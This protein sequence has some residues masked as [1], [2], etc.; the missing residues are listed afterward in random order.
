MDRKKVKMWEKGDTRGG[1]RRQLETEMPPQAPFERRK[2]RVKT[3]G[4][5]QVMPR[6]SEIG[7]SYRG[8]EKRNV[9][10]DYFLN[11]DVIGK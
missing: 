7:D 5:F 3:F 6:W 11:C 4:S 1:D 8:V 10:S 9:G 2:G